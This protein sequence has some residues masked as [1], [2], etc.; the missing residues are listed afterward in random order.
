VGALL[1][2]R[3]LRHKTKKRSFQIALYIVI[4]VQVAAVWLVLRT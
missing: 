3:R 1:A 4:L 2:M